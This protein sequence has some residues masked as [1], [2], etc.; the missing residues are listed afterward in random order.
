MLLLGHSCG[1]D[2][3][4]EDGLNVENMSNSYGGKQRVI[5]PI[6]IRKERGYLG[7]FNCKLNPGNFQHI[8]FS[9]TDAGHFW[10]NPVEQEE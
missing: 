7:S 4:R 8:L 2:R 5:Q 3:Q 1:H 10:M 6:L 9:E